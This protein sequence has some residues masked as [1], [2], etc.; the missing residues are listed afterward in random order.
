M[1]ALPVAP[2]DPV[3]TRPDPLVLRRRLGALLIDSIIIGVV[4]AL[5]SVYFPVIH[6]RVAQPGAVGGSLQ[7]TLNRDGPDLIPRISFGAAFYF[8]YFALFEMLLGTTLG[9]MTM[10]LCVV[11]HT[12]ERVGWPAALVRNL[13]RPID[14]AGAYALGG[15]VTLMSRH[16][17]RIGDHVAGTLVVDASSVRES[18]RWQPARGYRWRAGA[19]IILFFVVTCTASYFIPPPMRY[20]PNE[21]LYPTNMFVGSSLPP[22]VRRID[23]VRITSGAYQPGNATYHVDFHLRVGAHLQRRICHYTF[24]VRWVSPL[25]GWTEDNFFGGCGVSPHT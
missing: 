23:G 2:L 8:L 19:L 3:A 16:R 14:A 7:L 6:L 18:A 11:T 17:M 22:N 10:R 15:F 5:L 12:G 13:A 25:G 20:A 1:A 24:G 21:A 9:K 4:A